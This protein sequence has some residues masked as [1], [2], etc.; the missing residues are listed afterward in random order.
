MRIYV[1]IIFI[2]AFT[3]CNNENISSPSD[4]YVN[5]SNYTIIKK[6]NQ[7]EL[8]SLKLILIKNLIILTW[9]K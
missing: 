5:Q 9:P 8:D 6:L 1:F 2:I 4:D 3:S 7:T